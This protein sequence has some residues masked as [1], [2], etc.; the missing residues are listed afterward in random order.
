MISANWKTAL[1]RALNLRNAQVLSWGLRKVGIHIVNVAMGRLLGE[2]ARD[3]NLPAP[4]PARRA[5][6]IARS[7]FPRSDR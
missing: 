7:G 2:K 6:L 4:Y 3:P 1:Q 5:E